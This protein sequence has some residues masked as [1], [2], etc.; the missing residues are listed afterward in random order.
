MLRPILMWNKIG[1]IVMLLSKRLKISPEAA[2]DAFYR[3]WTNERLHDPNDFL[4]LMG[5]LYIVD[6][7][8]L[9]QQGFLR[10]RKSE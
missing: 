10:K 4:Y 6:D 9:E 3:S 5:D 2:L 1:R 7:F 8:I